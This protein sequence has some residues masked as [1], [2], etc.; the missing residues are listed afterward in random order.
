MRV[1]VYGAGAVGGFFGGLLARAGEDVHFV[2]RGIQLQALRARGLTINSRRLGSITVPVSTFDSAAAA[3]S[4]DL[5]LVCVKTQQLPGIFDDLATVVGPHTVIVPLQ[6]GVEAD[7]QLSVRFP[8]AVVLPSVVYV[9]ATV[10]EPGVV[11]HVASGTIGI[12]A[13]RDE[14]RHVLAA[15]RDTLAKTGQPVHISNDIQRE[16]WHKLMWNAAF[17][18]VSA[19]TGRVP[20]D[21]LAQPDVRSLIVN[22]MSEVL[23]VGRGCGVDLRPEDIDKHIA[24]TEGA[25]GMR[26]STMVDREKGRAMEIDGL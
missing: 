20:A 21:L 19:L 4:A 8:H 1:L 5:V 13:N 25:T 9:G 26:T 24:W 2:A 11:T 22:I 10:D 23:A 18:S 3:G 16:R 12:G 7:A 14:D 15:V 6:N 17:N